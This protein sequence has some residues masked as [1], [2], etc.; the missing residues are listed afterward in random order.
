MTSSPGKVVLITGASS[1][2]GEATARHLAERGHSIV[3]GARR[4]DRIATIAR[5][6]ELAGGQAFSR[7]LD[8][9]DLDSVKAFIAA[10]KAAGAN[11]DAARWEARVQAVA[12]AGAPP[13]P[14][15]LKTDKA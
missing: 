12:R 4:T 5:D 8:V 10:A 3:L 6:I 15:I 14:K 7:E 1:G 13:L 9:T 2:I 11:I